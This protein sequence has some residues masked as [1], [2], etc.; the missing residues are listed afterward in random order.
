MRRRSLFDFVCSL[1]LIDGQAPL[2]FAPRA[3]FSA[4]VPLGGRRGVGHLSITTR[5]VAG[6]YDRPT[7]AAK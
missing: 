7:S 4:P 3:P 1:R 2:A 5:H 6:S